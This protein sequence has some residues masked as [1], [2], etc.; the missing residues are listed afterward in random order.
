MRPQTYI[1]SCSP[2]RRL[3]GGLQIMVIGKQSSGAAR[4]RSSGRRVGSGVGAILL[5]AMLT[6]AGSA[7]AKTWDS[8]TQVDFAASRD[9]N[10][11]H[12]GMDASGN[13]LLVWT[14]AY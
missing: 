10:D 5:A 6:P 4:I 12:V 13:F 1:R 2:T 8:P 3:Q 14:P 11:M 9:P 7:L